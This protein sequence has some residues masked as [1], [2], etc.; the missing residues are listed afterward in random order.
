MDNTLA[1]VPTIDQVADQTAEDL[2]W[3]ADVWR[4]GGSTALETTVRNEPNLTFALFDS[5]SKARGCIKLEVARSHPPAGIVRLLQP[6]GPGTPY[7][8]VVD[9]ADGQQHEAIIFS[10]CISANG[11]RVII[12]RG[13]SP[14]LLV[15]D[16]ELCSVAVAPAGHAFIDQVAERLGVTACEQ[17]RAP[18]F[19]E[20]GPDDFNLYR[21]VWWDTARLLEILDISARMLD[22]RLSFIAGARAIG[23]QCNIGIEWLDTD[24]AIKTIADIDAYIRDPR[25]FQRMP[26]PPE[27]QRAERG[28]TSWPL[29]NEL[30]RVEAWARQHCE[31]ACQSLID[32]YRASPFS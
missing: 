28:G 8:T 21:D 31:P 26:A 24:P 25:G 1:T 11:E 12:A 14:F 17:M 32:R 10:F 9:L 30:A 3:L 13:Y 22:G 15:A 2:R 27:W 19:T 29:E 18:E 4:T 20:L 5:R 6:M 23:L 7:M 16:P